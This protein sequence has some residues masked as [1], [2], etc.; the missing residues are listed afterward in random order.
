MTPRYI[1]ADSILAKVYLVSAGAFIL[2]FFALRI[3]ITGR[4][5]SF[6]EIATLN[7]GWCQICEDGSRK[8]FQVGDNLHGKNYEHILIENTLPIGLPAGVSFIMRSSSQNVYVRID[9]STRLVYDPAGDSSK[10]PPSKFLSVPL[11]NSDSGKKIQ[12]ITISSG[13]YS[14]FTSSFYL[15]NETDFAHYIYQKYQYSLYALYFLFGFSIMSMIVALIVKF[16]FKRM[17]RCAP[18]SLSG[19]LIS[20]FLLACTPIREYYFSNLEVLDIIRQLGIYSFWIPILK[21]LDN[22]M[23]F[24]HYKLIFGNKIILFVLMLSSGVILLS[25]LST[26]ALGL[27]FASIT[28]ILELGVILYLLIVEMKNRQIKNYLGSATFCLLLIPAQLLEIVNVT[29]DKCILACPI[30]VIVFSGMIAADIVSQL[31]AAMNIERKRAE[32]VSAS[33]SKSAFLANMSHEIRTPVNS[34]MGM[35]EM[36]LRECSD[37]NLIDYSRNIKS[38]SEYLLGILN[39][40]L[41]F[42]KIEAGKLEMV[43]DKY[44]P[45]TMFVDLM[46]ILNER[47]EKKDL[48]VVFKVSEDMPREVIGDVTRVKQ[49]V[50]NLIS[51]AVKYTEKGTVTLNADCEI[52]DSV[53]NLKITVSDTGIGMTEEGLSK[54]FDKFTRL[55]LKKNINIEGTG[56]GMTITKSLLTMMGGSIDVASK[57]G[58]GSTF[59]V[60]IPQVISDKAPIGNFINAAHELSGEKNT[61]SKVTPFTA[62]E[63][64][65]LVVDDNKLNRV[66]FT[67]LLKRTEIKVEEADSGLKAI[68]L[69]KNIHYDVIFMDHM[70]PEPDGI[71]TLHMLRDLDTPNNDT[72]VI[73]LTANAISGLKPQYLSQ[74]F[75]DY[76]SKPI[77]ADLLDEK[78][79]EFLPENLIH[80]N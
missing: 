17:L 8:S 52:S 80:K 35:N 3:F 5:D 79:M 41:D 43:E 45:A 49:I 72:P 9:G 57:Y 58:E 60:T 30:F 21:Y 73:V 67:K 28:S 14:G 59:A 62:P 26:I 22:I 31:S 12:V 18:L 42:S 36:I 48:A 11:R 27:A 78:L 56:L 77:K 65:V 51:N 19:L 13:I 1:K 53:C 54:L 68:E 46:R 24:R 76:M 44:T 61:V 23:E 20:I 2:L 32:A 25:P 10:M 33:E 70:M 29:T 64:S 71:E 40:I 75:S 16:K 34:I 6:Y 7:K 69:C 37:S 15:S 66:V 4:D 55:D 38:S 47:A 50:I 63:A 39:D 74:G